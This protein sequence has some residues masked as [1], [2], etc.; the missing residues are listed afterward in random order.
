MSHKATTAD[1]EDLLLKLHDKRSVLL[2]GFT[3]FKPRKTLKII[4]PGKSREARV[5]FHYE[6]KNP[7]KETGKAFSRTHN[8]PL[9]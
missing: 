4:S 5:I 7:H 8:V 6:H 9:F 1:G 2:S 3:E